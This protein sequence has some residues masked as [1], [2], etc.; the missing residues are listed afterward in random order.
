MISANDD[1]VKNPAV[2]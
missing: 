1:K 2:G